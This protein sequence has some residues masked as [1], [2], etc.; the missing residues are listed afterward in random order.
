MKQERKVIATE[1]E[2]GGQKEKEMEKEC[3]RKS[4]KRQCTKMKM[5]AN[6][7]GVKTTSINKSTSIVVDQGHYQF[8]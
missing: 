7:V 2:S 4:G 8:Q 3:I 5:L 1:R 6:T